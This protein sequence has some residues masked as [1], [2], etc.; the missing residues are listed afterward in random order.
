MTVTITEIDSIM[1]MDILT[2][3]GITETA[4]IMEMGMGLF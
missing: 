2:E 4:N 1:V 3:M